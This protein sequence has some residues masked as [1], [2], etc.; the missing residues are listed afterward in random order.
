MIDPVVLS[1]NILAILH[2][3]AR[4]VQSVTH[5]VR[6]YTSAPA[7]L[8]DIRAESER[9]AITLLL[10]QSALHRRAAVAAALDAQSQLQTSFDNVLLGCLATFK[11]LDRDLL[12]LLVAPQLNVDWLARS[13]VTLDE[14]MIEYYLSRLKGNMHALNL[15]LSCLQL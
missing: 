14:V 9:I 6:K 11:L 1:V 12:H 8:A 3:N 13:V 5:L 15:L 10:L 7:E 4:T 2:T